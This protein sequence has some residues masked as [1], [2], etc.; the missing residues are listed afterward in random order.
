MC[1]WQLQAF[2]P[3][4]SPPHIL[5]QGFTGFLSELLS[6]LSAHPRVGWCCLFLR[7]ASFTALTGPCLYGSAV[8]AQSLAPG[9]CGIL[10]F[11]TVSLAYKSHHPIFAKFEGPPRQHLP[12]WWD[13]LSSSPYLCRCMFPMLDILILFQHTHILPFC[14]DL[15]CI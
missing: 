9:V 12:V 1:P 15:S 10:R 8:F 6:G 3:P 2:R 14:W 7:K 4:A 5:V 11:V 13:N